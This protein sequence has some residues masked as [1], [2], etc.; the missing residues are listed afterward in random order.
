MG[1]LGVAL[2]AALLLWAYRFMQYREQVRLSQARWLTYEPTMQVFATEQELGISW[3]ILA[4]AMLSPIPEERLESGRVR[5]YLCLLCS[6]IV[7][8]PACVCVA[9]RHL[10]H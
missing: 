4:P 1:V 6:C 10:Q 7:G 2:L 5:P 3:P 9:L 8:G